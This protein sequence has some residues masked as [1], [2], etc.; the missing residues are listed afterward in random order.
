M[1]I[2]KWIL[3]FASEKE[4][5]YETHAGLWLVMLSLSIYLQKLSSCANIFCL[6]NVFEIFCLKLSS[7]LTINILFDTIIV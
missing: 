2:F 3:L 6:R 4:S 5:L 1:T 7:L